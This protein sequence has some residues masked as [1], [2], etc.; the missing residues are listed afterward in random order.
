M[1]DDRVLPLTRWTAWAV[2]PVL[3]AGGVLLYGF[4]ADT[5]RLWAWPVAPPLTA[6][7]MGGGY[8][9]GAAF[10]ARAAARGRWHEMAVGFV[11]ASVLSVLLLA[12]TLLHWDR[13]TH[14]HPAF[15]G[16]LGVYLAA[17]VVLPLVWWRNRRH[18]PG[19]DG[20]QSVPERLRRGVG[21]LGAAL[22]AVAAGVFAAPD[23]AARLWPWAVS[24]LTARSLS[25]FVAFIAVAL[26][27]FAVEP[28]WSALRLHVDSAA[29]GLALVG[30]GALRAPGDLDA[31]T[32]A[33]LAFALLL[34][35]ML[36]GL[37]W[38]RTALGA[39]GAARGG[40][41]RAGPVV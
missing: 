27:A 34:A 30:V 18:D 19:P 6:M 14:G 4:P 41:G 8:L 33:T 32:P 20:S 26:A 2:V 29:L 13:F 3:L 36:G 38:L 39:P 31:G 22:L 12:A 25:A 23:A 5:E 21:S 24:P 35:G 17:P 10:F 40:P 15:W 1:R 7:A 11:G 37:V 9:A 16:W 28:R